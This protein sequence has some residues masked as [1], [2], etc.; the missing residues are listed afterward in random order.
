LSGL[1][2]VDMVRE[3]LTL[4]DILTREAFENAINVNA[5]IGGSTNFVIHLLAIAGR[6]GID[7]N[8]E[9]F[10][11]TVRKIPLLANIQPSGKYFMEDLYYAGG[12]PA[13]MK[14][15][16]SVLHRNAITVNGKTVGENLAGVQAYGP[17]VISEW[18]KPF[19]AHAG[20]AVLKGNLCEE[21]AVI[22]P[23]AA[24]ENLMVH[25]GKAVVFDN[26]EDYKQRIDDPNLDVDENS[27]LVLKNVGP[28]GYPGMPEVGNMALP[29]KILEKGVHDMV[30]ISD[31]RMSGTGFGTVVL[32]AS[33]EATQGGNFALVQSGDFIS[34]DVSKRTLQLEVSDSVLE[35]RRKNWKPFEAPVKRGYVQ[36][37]I[38][39]V[40]QSHLGADFDFLKGGSGSE[41][42]RDSH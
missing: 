12:L 4:S 11:N 18:E 23:S 38:S 37:Y 27:V 13:V 32:H 8:L 15:M 1:R 33:P 36:L 40:E 3:S 41:V 19:N 21:G 10:D 29:K 42:T 28:R 9:D 16:E 35:K 30:R 24:S 17:D 7:L 14:Q 25:R 31:G 5:A 2:I 22:K 39:H 6:I 26:I 34:L 20:I